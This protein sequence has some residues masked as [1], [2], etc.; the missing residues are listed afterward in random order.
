MPIR[1]LQAMFGYASL[2]ASCGQVQATTP[3]QPESVRIVAIGDLH[4]DAAAAKQT[5]RLAG[6]VDEAGH[7]SGGHTVLVQTG[8]ITDRG[9]DSRT[10]MDW[11]GTLAVEAQEAGGEVRSLVG[12]HEAMNLLGDWRY[13]H[14]GDVEQFGGLE[15][16]KAAFGPGGPYAQWVTQRPVATRVDDTVFVHGG[17]SP[18]F[19]AQGI[20]SL[21]DAARR[22]LV[23]RDRS[24]AVLGTDGPLWHRDYV[25]QDESTA[26]PSLSTALDA[27]G[28]RRMVVGHTTRRDGRAAVRCGGK[29]I[30]IDI[31][32][33]A[34]Y[35]N[36][37][38]ALEIIDGDARFFY[39]HGI[40]DL[41]D[42]ST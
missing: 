21:N 11:L 3:T 24:A 12:N 33:A 18:Q 8:D 6:L 15:A 39:P 17:I 27:L 42:P 35:G 25:Q 23:A 22:A 31:G 2:L 1:T 32:I 26:C 29:L 7:W 28:A 4:G 20:E 40:E 16:R 37:P 34:H 41:E 10:L 5:L 19:A 13:V 9:P 38:G 30:V 36:H 14:P